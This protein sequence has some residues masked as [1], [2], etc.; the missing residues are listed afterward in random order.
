MGE[1]KGRGAGG[2]EKYEDIDKRE[3]I[4]NGLDR[5]RCPLS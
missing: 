5:V 2:E 1:K 3:A 4:N